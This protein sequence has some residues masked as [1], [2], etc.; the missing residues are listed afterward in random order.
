M[1]YMV[2][3]LGYV[4]TTNIPMYITKYLICSLSVKTQIQM[5]IY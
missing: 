5:K 3:N 2:G 1:W 4:E